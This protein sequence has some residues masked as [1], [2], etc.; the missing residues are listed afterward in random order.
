VT[1]KGTP[2]RGW[3]KV[4]ASVWGHP[5]D[6]QIYLELDATSLLAF[7]EEARRLT[8]AHV[9]VAHAIGK[10]IA[11]ALA[12][13]PDLNVRLYRGR[14]LRVGGHLLRGV[15]RRRQR[16]FGDQGHLI[17]WSCPREVESRQALPRTRVGKIDFVALMRD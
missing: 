2:A 17:E 7:I 4:A 16:R 13:N 6:P 5:S 14:F 1:K 9:P 15:H 10:A 3:R 12:E 8:G 11:H